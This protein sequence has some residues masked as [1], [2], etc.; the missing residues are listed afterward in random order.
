MPVAVYVHEKLPDE[1]DSPIRE[2]T[3]TLLLQIEVLF[4][5]LLIPIFVVY[6]FPQAGKPQS[7]VT[8][9][10]IAAEGQVA[11]IQTEVTPTQAMVAIQPPAV[12]VATEPTATPTPPVTKKKE[13]K[14]AVIGDS[15]V[16]TMGERLEY[17]EHALKKKY[18]NA[19]FTLYNYG[20]GSQNV[21][22]GLGRFDKP[23]K[24]KDRDYPAVADIKPD[25]IVV[26]SF[27]YNPFT[28][29]DRDKH[30]LTLTQ[31][32]QKAQ[33]ITPDV[34]MLAEIAPLTR[35]FGKG[36]NGVNWDTATAV[37]H[38]AHIEQQLQNVIGLGLTLNVPVI[39]AYTPS[40]KDNEGTK[41]YV[42]PGD[43]IHP[44]VKGHEFM[45]EIMVKSISL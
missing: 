28:P 11:G 27:A 7:T 35:E 31:M 1:S 30:W 25:I 20:I 40:K 9:S 38:A 21:E 26:G 12:T 32:V 17:F 36:P 24:Y 23:F 42:S 6:M 33:Q 2:N 45:A 15:M 37:T 44:S 10:P 22:D 13:Y 16:D 14:I 41:D 39:D 8:Q 29:H 18:P 5:L 43:G 3:S 19:N 34:Y 4:L